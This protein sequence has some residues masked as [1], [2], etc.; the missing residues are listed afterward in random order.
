MFL[1]GVAVSS[2]GREIATAEK[3]PR[4]DVI[5]CFYLRKIP[6]KVLLCADFL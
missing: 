6:E 5:Y 4:N 2:I 3:L 1:G